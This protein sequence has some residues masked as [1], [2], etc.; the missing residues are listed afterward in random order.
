MEQ[1]PEPSTYRI[2]NPIAAFQP[3]FRCLGHVYFSYVDI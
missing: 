1:Q 2:Q 3:G